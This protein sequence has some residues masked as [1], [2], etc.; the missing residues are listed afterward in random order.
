MDNFS[1]EEEITKKTKHT[2]EKVSESVEEIPA[3]IRDKKCKSTLKEKVQVGPIKSTSHPR[4]EI[5][6]N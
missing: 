1:S 4:G 5:K 6:V 3:K 2:I